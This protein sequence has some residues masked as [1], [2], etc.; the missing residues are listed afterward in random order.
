MKGIR[1]CVNSTLLSASRPEINMQNKSRSRQR[2]Q[3]VVFHS[4]RSVV[5][6]FDRNPRSQCKISEDLRDTFDVN[7]MAWRINRVK[8]RVKLKLMITV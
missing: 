7:M 5:F 8:T 2:R 3:L 6:Y 4:D 1:R